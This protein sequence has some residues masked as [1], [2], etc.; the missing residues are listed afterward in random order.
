[1]YASV[2]RVSMGS[3]SGLS[4]V[5]RQAIIETN[6]GIL[7]ILPFGTNLMKFQLYYK[8]FLHENAFESLWNG[9]HFVQGEMS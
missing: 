1:M 8:I 9:G 6:A 5:W 7:L 2:Y 4:P 3:D